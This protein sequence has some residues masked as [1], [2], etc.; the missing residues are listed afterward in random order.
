MTWNAA[1]SEHWSKVRNASLLEEAR[2]ARDCPHQ[3][4]YMCSAFTVSRCATLLRALLAMP[5]STAR[6]LPFR[7]SP[8][9]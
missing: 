1:A 6:N 3:Q 5:F 7:S 8:L 9:R 2:C 4:Q